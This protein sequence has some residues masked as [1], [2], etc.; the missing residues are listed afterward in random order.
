MTFPGI[1]SVVACANQK[2]I[3]YKTT[4]LALPKLILLHY[5]LCCHK[6]ECYGSDKLV[7]VKKRSIYLLYTH[8]K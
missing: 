7:S 1:E 3:E 5:L 6:K 8:Y 2:E 4:A